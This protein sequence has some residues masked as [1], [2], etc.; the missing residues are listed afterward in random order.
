M[1]DELSVY[2]SRNKKLIINLLESTKKY[3][4]K[5]KSSWKKL[6]TVR[7]SLVAFQVEVSPSN[8]TMDLPKWITAW[9][10]WNLELIYDVRHKTC[11][12]QQAHTLV[13]S[14]YVISVINMKTK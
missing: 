14:L 9:D 12:K 2:S 8:H 4:Q 6:L 13:I 3:R 11:K 1:T 5:R 10:R 7:D